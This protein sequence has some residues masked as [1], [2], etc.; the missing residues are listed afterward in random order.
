MEEARL[1]EIL[2]MLRKVA[3]EAAK[4]MEEAIQIQNAHIVECET[5]LH[6]ARIALVKV[7]KWSNQYKTVKSGTMAEMV[8]QAEKAATVMHAYLKIWGV[9][10]EAEPLILLAKGGVGGH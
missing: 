2:D 8:E 5:V 9:K 6:E 4:E 7:F 3:P 1:L 10:K